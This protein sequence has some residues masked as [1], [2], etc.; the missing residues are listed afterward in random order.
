MKKIKFWK[1]TDFQ[2]PECGSSAE[3]NT[4]AVADFYYDGDELKCTECDATGQI[5]VDEGYGTDIWD[6]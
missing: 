3:V 2:C 4:S 1:S 5:S 6:W